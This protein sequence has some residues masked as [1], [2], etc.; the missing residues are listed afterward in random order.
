M[1]RAGRQHYST[2][3]LFLGWSSCTCETGVTWITNVYAVFTWIPT[4]C[5]IKYAND[6]MGTVQ[7]GMEL[8]RR[9]I[10]CRKI[11]DSRQCYQK[12]MVPY[13]R[14]IVFRSYG[15]PIPQTVS[16]Y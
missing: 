8:E 14:D 6:R 4:Y 15:E 5:C 9:R 13:I 2:R 1:A 3:I 10:Q 12:E 11:R 7:I 16:I